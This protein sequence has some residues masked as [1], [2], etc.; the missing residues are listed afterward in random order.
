VYE[1]Y[2]KGG[3]LRAIGGGGRYDDLLKQFGGPD[4]PATGFG[5]GDCVLGVMLEE[6][7]LLKP[8]PH[9]LDY[10]VACVAPELS[11]QDAV[12]I[13]AELRTK[14]Y[15][16]DFS[17]KSASLS[18]QLKQASA[19]NAKKCIILG[20]EFKSNELVVKDMTTSKQK[21]IKL[22]AFFAELKSPLGT[23]YGAD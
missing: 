13:V 7:G 15:S 21:L 3:E 22:D 4:I 9:G 8:V 5:M 10:F 1:I 23:P 19:Q 12:K 14:G 6:R 2:D 20:D 18:R 16:A 17:Y 11:C